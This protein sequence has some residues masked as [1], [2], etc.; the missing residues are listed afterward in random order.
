[1]HEVITLSPDTVQERQMSS[2]E[3]ID[4]KISELL[5]GVKLISQI[6][7]CLRRD[8]Q[9]EAS[10]FFVEEEFIK[11]AQEKEAGTQLCNQLTFQYQRFIKRDQRYR[12]FTVIII[13]E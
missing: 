1:M 9:N 2:L 10:I 11:V 5:E 6:G 12:S 8:I 3:P 7:P 4:V 13:D